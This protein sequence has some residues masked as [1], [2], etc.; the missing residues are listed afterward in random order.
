LAG[1]SWDG[2][3]PP[4]PAVE[5]AAQNAAR[6]AQR[7]TEMIADALCTPGSFKLT[8]E[9]LCE[10]N[11]LAVAGLEDHPGVLRQK[12]L[13]I[14]GSRHVP[15]PWQDVAAQVAEMCSYVNQGDRDAVHRAAY[16]LWR[17]NWIHPF[18]DGNGRTARAA[19]YLVL[20]TALDG[21]LPGEVT[22][23]ERM[24]WQK[25]RYWRCLEAA[26]RAWDK[27]ALDLSALEEF[28]EEVLIAQLTDA[29]PG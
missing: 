22:I 14:T 4:D 19:C 28:L 18:G 3:G 11:A 10:L 26:D 13:T 6:Q 7:L 2:D 12:D 27:G 16:T 9:I 15:P 17:T 1:W 5:R 8:P 21:E 20:C 25:I 23:L 24:L 29:E